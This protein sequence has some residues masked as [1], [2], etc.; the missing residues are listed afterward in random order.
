V[1]GRLASSLLGLEVF[2]AHEW[3]ETTRGERLP[4]PVREKKKGNCV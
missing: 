2:R 3:K 1:H 4:H